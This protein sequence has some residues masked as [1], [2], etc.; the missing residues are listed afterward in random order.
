MAKKYK[1]EMHLHTG[2]TGR[3]AK[4]PAKEAVEDYVKIGYDGICVT[5]HLD[6][7][8]L[9]EMDGKN[10]EEK[11]T[12]WL[13]GYRLAKRHAEKFKDF[14]VILGAEIRLENSREEFLLYGIDGSI[15]IELADMF[16]CSQKQLYEVG[17]RVGFIV[18]QA[19]PFR[20]GQIP[21]KTKYIH[22]VEVYNSNPRHENRNERAFLFAE[23]N[24]KIMIS[25]SDYHQ[26][27]D[28]GGAGMIFPERILDSDQMA[29]AL[30]EAKGTIIL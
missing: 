28:V 7:S 29:K 14:D 11:M 12:S 13:S 2:E 6:K 8:M 5:N 26:K 24:N 22:G 21:A 15:L 4:V 27:E 20:N 19:H 3:C 16:F 9:E 23:E 30:V 1:Y 25:G 17:E 18:C 10:D